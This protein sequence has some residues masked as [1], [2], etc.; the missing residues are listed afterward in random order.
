MRLIADRF[1]AHSIAMRTIIQSGLLVLSLAIAGCAST[2]RR[3]AI[4]LTGDIMID[5]P[6]AIAEGPARD[7][8]LWQYRTA[9]AAMHLGRFDMA[10]SILDDALLT[11]GGIHVGDKSAKEARGLFGA[12][13]EKTFIG[14]PYER[15]MA[16]YYRGILYWMDGEPDNARACFRSGQLMDSVTR[17]ET[18]SADYVLLDY[19]D[20]LATRKLGGDGSDK[21]ELARGESRIVTPPDFQPEANVLFFVEFGPGP[22]KYATGEYAEK[23]R[24][25]THP[26]PVHSVRLKAGGRTLEMKPFDDLNFQATTR[27]GRE[28]DHILA[29]KAVFKAGTDTFGNAAIISGAIL[30]QHG[31]RKS[32]ADEIGLGLVAAGLISKIFS[33]A[34]T[35]EADV[36]SWD[37]LPQFLSFASLELAPGEHEAVVEFYNANG[38]A[39][40]NLTKR[41]TIN[42]TDTDRDKVVYVSDKSLTPQTI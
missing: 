42:V 29:N 22:V 4:P 16:F 36:R 1:P 8:V 10:R 26:S 40:P 27:G 34:T 11:I 24:I 3:P 25:R 17:N 33:A 28:M 2:Q 31:G 30:A 37:N 41:I 9:A 7:K 32:N 23:L 18:Y 20:G 6:R 39:M 13:A 35:P 21:L 19:L 5:G 38:A 14:E 12:E 15:V